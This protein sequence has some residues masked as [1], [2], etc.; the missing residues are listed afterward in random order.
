MNLTQLERLNTELKRGRYC[1][2][3][4]PYILIDVTHFYWSP[5]SY[6]QGHMDMATKDPRGGIICGGI[7]FYL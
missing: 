4:K 6:T 3:M 5:A 7:F 2:F 1:I